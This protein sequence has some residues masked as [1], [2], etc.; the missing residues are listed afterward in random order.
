MKIADIIKISIASL[1]FA[2]L[3]FF[4]IFLEV[5]IGIG[6]PSNEQYNSFQEQL[7]SEIEIQGGLLCR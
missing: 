4:V 2:I 3:I 7:K 5:A 1:Y 6:V